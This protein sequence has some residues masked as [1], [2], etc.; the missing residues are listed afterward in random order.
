MGTNEDSIVA[1][2]TCCYVTIMCAQAEDHTI[3]SRERKR[4]GKVFTFETACET[5]LNNHRA[6]D[7]VV[8]YIPLFYPDWV[9]SCSPRIQN[10]SRATFTV[11]FMRRLQFMGNYAY[12]YYRI[13][14]ICKKNTGCYKRCVYINSTSKLHQVF[15][16]LIKRSMIMSL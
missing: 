6:A 3:A 14:K 2:S 15:F 4:S 13:V 1:G 10:N 8:A 12:Y 5:V 16:S 9:L 7:E 11:I